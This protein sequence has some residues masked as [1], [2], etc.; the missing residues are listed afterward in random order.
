MS[1]GLNKKAVAWALAALL[2][3][4]AAG[5]W[6]WSAHKKRE[7]RGAVAELLLD[8]TRRFDDALAVESA[9]A[10]ADG[11]QTVRKLDDQAQEV[12]RHVLELHGLSV[13]ADRAL[14][15]AA[16]DYLLTVREILRRQAATH[17]YGIQVAASDAALRDHMRGAGRRSKGWI[18]EAVRLKDRMEKDYFDYHLAA[19]AF[20]RLLD[21]Y[22]ATREKL[23]AQRPA[24]APT[25]DETVRAARKRAA[26]SA[27]RID[28]EMRQARQLAAVH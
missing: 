26:Q 6:A 16:E 10:S 18:D 13:S 11:A 8:A 14:A 27:K 21:S 7:L 15:E 25:P 24:A 28:D 1:D 5:T 3:L 22:P 17:R 9:P 2:A 20:G 23:A 4:A 19:D 12:D